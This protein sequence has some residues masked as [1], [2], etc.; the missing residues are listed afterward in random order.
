MYQVPADRGNGIKVLLYEGDQADAEKEL[1]E[2]GFLFVADEITA[3]SVEKKQGFYRVDTEEEALKVIQDQ[4][5]VNKIERSW[6]R[7]WYGIWG[8]FPLALV[9]GLWMLSRD[10]NILSLWQWM[11]F[12][13]II[14]VIAEIKAYLTFQV[15]YYKAFH[16]GGKRVSS[17][18]ERRESSNVLTILLGGA[19][20]VIVIAIMGVLDLFGAREWGSLAIMISAGIAIFGPIATSLGKSKATTK[21]AE[22]EVANE[23]E[24][25][26]IGVYEIDD[27]VAFSDIL[28]P[29]GRWFSVYNTLFRCRPMNRPFPK[30]DIDI[31]TTAMCKDGSEGILKVFLYG[32]L[33]ID[34]PFHFVASLKIV[35]GVAE[36]VKFLDNPLTRAARSIIGGSNK[37][38][39]LLTP[40]A[41]YSLIALKWVIGSFLTE[42]Q[43]ERILDP[44]QKS[45]IYIPL[46]GVNLN[47]AT[48]NVDPS[49]EQKKRLGQKAQ[50]LADREAENIEAETLIG[51]AKKYADEWKV[52]PAQAVDIAQ[53]ERDKR[54]AV[55]HKLELDPEQLEE[56]KKI[57]AIMNKLSSDQ[58]KSLLDLFKKKGGH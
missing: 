57:V 31:K 29:G 4:R 15:R 10:E 27:E 28:G 12:A 45:G 3:S 55:T 35:G 51:L 9:F 5:R 13:A 48:V 46:L 25:P 20:V 32:E 52:T 43:I 41:D 26:E 36:I 1:S 16:A 49:E 42:A 2:K 47:H 33:P 8:F 53:I 50:E 21:A 7:I 38:Q 17:D 58:L 39:E 40:D 14:E 34:N 23:E 44:S 24:P 56:I 11:V 30:M 18:L 6:K 19:F 37:I 54:S 22:T